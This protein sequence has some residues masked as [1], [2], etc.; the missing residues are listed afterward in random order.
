MQSIGVHPVNFLR[1]AIDTAK[2]GGSCHPNLLCVHLVRADSMRCACVAAAAGPSGTSERCLCCADYPLP[3]LVQSIGVEHLQ[4][5]SPARRLLER[6]VHVGGSSKRHVMLVPPPLRRQCASRFSWPPDRAQEWVYIRLSPADFVEFAR[7]S[8]GVQLTVRQVCEL[9][10]AESP[11][12]AA[13]ARYA[14]RWR[15]ELDAGL[16]GV[17]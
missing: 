16:R 4:V 1:A 11:H 10:V 7:F 9:F 5:A 6:S 13:Y 12:S 17:T 2:K 3:L 15:A 8:L 14:V